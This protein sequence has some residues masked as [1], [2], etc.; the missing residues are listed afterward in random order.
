MRRAG[1]VHRPAAPS[2]SARSSAK[3]KS[4]GAPSPSVARPFAILVV[5][6]TLAGCIF[7][8]DSEDP[9]TPTTISP[10]VE[11][12]Q[13]EVTFGGRV[14]DALSGD[15]VPDAE[16]RVDLAAEK[17]CRQESIV[18]RDWQVPVDAEGAFGPFTQPAPD[19]PTYR[20][21]V[22]V[23][24]PGYTREVVYIGPQQAAFAPNLTVVLHPRLAVDG[25][26]PPGTVVAMSGAA[27]PRF[28]VADANG[29]FR[30][31]D[32]RTANVS[33]VV[34]TP[35]THRALL[36]PPATVD[37]SNATGDGWALQ[38]VTKR[39]DGRP[40]AARVVAWNGTQLWSAAL[41]DE[42]GRFLL[43]LPAESAALR[44]EARTAD[45]QYGGVLARTLNGP[46][47]AS[48]TV[49]MRARC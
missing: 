32:A 36:T 1:H 49:L 11:P 35:A 6:A 46:P 34:A 37:A 29:T 42:V 24:A 44:I 2:L 3:A 14:L 22:H 15:A 5:A 13:Y 7:G 39:D 30:F 40:V 18:W 28:A 23:Q 8:S 27:F 38:G 48:E 16:V 26:A 10:T 21:F 25:A 47:A 9:P 12:F 17:P 33:L 31:D 4:L 41:T 19:S 43:P 20:F 45:D